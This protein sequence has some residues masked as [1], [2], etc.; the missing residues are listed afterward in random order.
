MRSFLVSVET[1]VMR[2]GTVDAAQKRITLATQPQGTDVWA[3]LLMHQA[4]TTKLKITLAESFPRR[5]TSLPWSLLWL[6]SQTFDVSGRTGPQRTNPQSA[7]GQ[8]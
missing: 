6:S 5:T 4:L 2:I 8:S 3:H 7:V 1:L